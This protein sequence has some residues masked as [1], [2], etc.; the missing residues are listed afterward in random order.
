MA[1]INRQL[2]A[3][4]GRPKK[5]EGNDVNN[6]ISPRGS[7]AAHTIARLKRDGHAELLAQIE[8]GETT[9][10]AVAVQLGWRARMI[11]HPPT[12]AGFAAAIRKN[13]NDAEIQ[14]LATAFAAPTE[15]FARLYKEFCRRRRELDC[16]DRRRAWKPDA[17]AK[18]ELIGILVWIGGELQDLA[19]GRYRSTRPAA[20][21]PRRSDARESDIAR[22]VQGGIENLDF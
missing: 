2:R 14:E 3:K 9:A 1:A 15:V 16:V 4:P 10:H 22:R 20:T 21:Q 18:V 6:I 11:Q 12:I 19:N 5:G 8:R 13:L 7:N 17:V